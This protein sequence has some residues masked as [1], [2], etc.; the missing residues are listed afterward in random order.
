MKTERNRV[1]GAPPGSLSMC[2]MT[3]TST[4]TPNVG[5]NTRPLEDR[6]SRM[7][8]CGTHSHRP[9]SLRVDHLTRGEIRVTAPREA[10]IKSHMRD[11]SAF[12]P[13]ILACSIGRHS[14]KTVRTS[15]GTKAL[16][17][18]VRGA[19]YWV[20]SAAASAALRALRRYL[21][22]LRRDALHPSAPDATRVARLNQR[23]PR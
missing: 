15:I 23:F 19:S 17:S 7:R 9:S 4:P 20:A 3:D 8:S 6:P 12:V 14:I 10:L 11:R 18:L 2:S 16:R 1:V 13:C 5:A 21:P 22:W